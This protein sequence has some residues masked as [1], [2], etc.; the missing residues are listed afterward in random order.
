ML[1]INTSIAGKSK[2]V[3]A[4]SSFQLLSVASAI[5]FS[6]CTSPVATFSATLALALA[7]A[8]LAC[9]S[10]F[11]FSTLLLIQLDARFA[12]G[13]ISAVNITFLY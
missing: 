11:T 2:T 9:P 8:T 6:H 1:G 13:P 5:D 10:A 4:N 12:I 3:K 7:S